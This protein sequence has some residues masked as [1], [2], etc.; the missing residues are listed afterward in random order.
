MDLDR[1]L[2]DEHSR[3]KVFERLLKN[4]LSVNTKLSDFNR[5]AYLCLECDRHWHQNKFVSVSIFFCSG[6]SG[7]GSDN[8][9]YLGIYT[10]EEE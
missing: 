2:D 9:E 7:C 10:E 8:I 6:K 1:T 4:H 5:H 3:S